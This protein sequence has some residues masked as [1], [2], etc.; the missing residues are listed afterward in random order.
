MKL[1]KNEIKDDKDDNKS[2][3]DYVRDK[4]YEEIFCL[5]T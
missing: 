1:I 3:K 5:L 2:F 4:I